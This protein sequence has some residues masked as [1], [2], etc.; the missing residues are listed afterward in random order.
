MLPSRMI[1]KEKLEEHFA[2]FKNA[3]FKN[4]HQLQQ[5]LKKKEN[6][7]ELTIAGLSEE[8]LTI[9]LREI[10]SIHPK[11]NKLK[12]FEGMNEEIISKLEKIGIKDTVA[13]FEK[14]KTPDDRKKLADKTGLTQDEIIV[15]TKLTDLSRIK[16]VGATFAR[17]L[18]EAGFDTAE[19]VAMADFNDLYNRITK[20]NKERN[21]YKGNIGL[22]DMK[23]CVLVA[24]DVPLEIEY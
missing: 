9:L 15:L 12:E 6:I 24:K 11:P 14:V 16:Y 1:L 3:G 19:K 4:V 20:L 5:L 13:L 10:N 17:V 18:Y 21:L 2:F 7:K 23:L 22:N 8:Y